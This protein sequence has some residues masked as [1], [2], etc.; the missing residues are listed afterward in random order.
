MWG[1]NLGKKR[2]KSNL[3]PKRVGRDRE[4]RPSSGSFSS[5]DLSAAVQGYV[6]YSFLYFVQLRQ[7]LV[8]LG[9][10]PRLIVTVKPR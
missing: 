3:A 8:Q 6:L 9:L 4:R 7:I 2:Y 10:N 1:D 5:S